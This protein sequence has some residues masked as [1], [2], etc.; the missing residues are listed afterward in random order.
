MGRFLPSTYSYGKS[1]AT[2]VCLS[3]LGTARSCGLRPHGTDVTD[4]ATVTVDADADHVL[5]AAQEQRRRWMVE[6]PTAG[7]V[8]DFPPGAQPFVAHPDHERHRHLQGEEMLPCGVIDPTVDDLPQRPAR[9]PNNGAGGRNEDDGDGAPQ[10]SFLSRIWFLF[11]NIFRTV[12]EDGG[13]GGGGGFDQKIDVPTYYHVIEGR[14]SN[15][16]SDNA[17]R[18]THND[19]N[20]AFRG[21]PFR[22]DFMEITRT[23]NDDWYGYD[24]FYTD[25][26][27]DMKSTLRRG[28]AESLNVY[29]NKVNGICG[30]AILPKFYQ[31]FALWDGTV[32]NENCFATGKG[33]AVTHE[34]NSN[35]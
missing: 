35:E 18:Q 21:T 4:D 5:A 29:I 3:L 33:G 26:E 6:R 19:L 10:D 23:Y 20:A 30:Y 7:A 12:L 15:S 31:D 9:A 13:G 28:G 2:L 24:G 16:P 27:R 1:I 17:V 11:V 34:G 22:F 8:A 25:D 32:V 14:G